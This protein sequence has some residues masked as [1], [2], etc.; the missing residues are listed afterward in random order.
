M[1]VDTA[2]KVSR[3]LIDK[4]ASGNVCSES[5]RA[6]CLQDMFR[7]VNWSQASGERNGG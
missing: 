4:A 1:I 5:G 2:D 3:N 7:Q 6:R